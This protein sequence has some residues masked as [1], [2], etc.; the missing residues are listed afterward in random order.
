LVAYDVYLLE[1]RKIEAVFQCGSEN[2]R[3]RTQTFFGGLEY[4]ALQYRKH[5]QS[6]GKLVQMLLKS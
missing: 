4:Y 1:G 5:E 2:I 6:F 3:P